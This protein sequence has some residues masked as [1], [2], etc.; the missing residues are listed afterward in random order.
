MTVDQLINELEKFDRNI[1]VAIKPAHSDY[2]SDI[3]DSMK[4]L[5][6]KDTW[7]GEVSN[8]LVIKANNQIGTL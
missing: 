7:N 8:I 2:I 1:E 3:D 6:V 5:D 4:C